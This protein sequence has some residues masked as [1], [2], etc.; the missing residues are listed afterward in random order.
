[1]LN[2]AMSWFIRR[3]SLS[4]IFFICDF[5]EQVID[6]NIQ[7]FKTSINEFSTTKS[8]PLI[9]FQTFIFKHLIRSL[10]FKSH[11]RRL[12]MRKK[13]TKNQILINTMSANRFII[14]TWLNLEADQGFRSQYS[15]TRLMDY[16]SQ[17]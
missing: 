3:Y 12:S 15:I 1:M 8:K 9:N 7:N 14:D 16:T 2:L 5:I 13:L 11:G 17:Q 4:C 6:F 10:V